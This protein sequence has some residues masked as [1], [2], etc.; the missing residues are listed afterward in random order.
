[1]FGLLIGALVSGQ[2]SDS[3]GRKLVKI[4]WDIEN[5]LDGGDKHR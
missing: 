5:Y 2:L 3:Y 4:L 1:M